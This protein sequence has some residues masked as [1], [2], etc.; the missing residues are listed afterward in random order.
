MKRVLITLFTI[1]LILLPHADFAQAASRTA[2]YRLYNPMSNDHFYTSDLNESTAAT[3]QGYVWEGIIGE[4][5]TT[6]TSSNVSLFRLYSPSL[7]NHFYTASAQEMSLATQVGFRL[8]GVMGYM[9][10]GATTLQVYRLYHSSGDHFYTTDFA[11]RD[12]AEAAG[13]RVENSLGYLFVPSTV[14]STPLTKGTWGGPSLSMNVGSGG[15]SLEYD[16]A[17]GTM[18]QPVNV[19][20]AGNFTATG[21]YTQEHGGPSQQDEVLPTYPVNYNG[22]ISGNSMSLTVTRSDVKQDFGTYQLTYGQ[23]GSVFKCL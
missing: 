3:N 8:E 1:S 4:L 2:L 20:S 6:Q 9:P 13:Y 12:R 15:I 11:E 7:N 5:E 21:S 23:T 18:D 17:S 19:D 16:C 14:S 22:Q 10:S